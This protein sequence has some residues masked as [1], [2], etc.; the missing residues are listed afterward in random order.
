MEAIEGLDEAAKTT[1]MKEAAREA[2]NAKVKADAGILSQAKDDVFLVRISAIDGSIVRPNSATPKNSQG[3]MYQGSCFVCQNHDNVK[4]KSC[5]ECLLCGTIIC[6]KDRGR[7]MS[8]IYEHLNSSD[9]EIKCD[10]TRKGNS[11]LKGVIR[12]N[13]S[14]YYPP[15]LDNNTTGVEHYTDKVK[16]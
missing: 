7:G 16:L 13:S 15:I 5:Y 6:T 10:G 9:P 11:T 8:C 14:G 2:L 12:R 1:A 4:S 3:T